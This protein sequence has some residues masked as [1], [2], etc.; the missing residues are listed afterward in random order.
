MI[1]Y[2]I[3]SEH[4]TSHISYHIPC[5]VLCCHIMLL[6]H[7]VLYCIVLY[8]LVSRR[9]VSHRVPPWCVASCRIHPISSQ[10]IPSHFIMLCHMLRRLALRRVML[11]HI[12]SDMN[13]STFKLF[14]KS[15]SWLQETTSD[16]YD[17][18]YLDIEKSRGTFL[19]CI[20]RFT[21]VI[22][23]KESYSVR[24]L[25]QCCFWPLLRTNLFTKADQI[26]YWMIG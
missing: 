18:C 15:V 10:S 26:A 12:L 4:S 20:A 8:R 23:V 16:V 19:N 14:Q 1:W 9:Y 25:L 22:L 17:H 13:S 5:V 6:Y 21:N 3:T 2:H 24:M 7:I 11:Y